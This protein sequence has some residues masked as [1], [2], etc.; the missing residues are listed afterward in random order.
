[1]KKLLFTLLLII[2]SLIN[3]SSS[4]ACDG[5]LLE[6]LKKERDIYLGD[7]HGTNEIPRL[8]QCL[9]EQLI[10]LDRKEPLVVALE[11]VTL[12]LTSNSEVWFGTDGRNSAAM[13]D[14]IQYLKE[15]KNLGNI[16][17]FMLLDAVDFSLIGEPFDQNI[18]EKQ[19]GIGLRSIVENNQVIALSGSFH[20]KK[21]APS[22]A[23]NIVPAGSYVSD[24]MLHVAIETIEDGESW[25]CISTGCSVKKSSSIG[26]A[27]TQAGEM[28]NG[29]LVDHDY[30]YFLPK[31]TASFPKFI[32]SK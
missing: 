16:N 3:I 22:F 15:Q 4:Y 13:W 26:I 21:K 14:L 32:K 23:P 19:I 11:E 8:L 6:L 28:V 17:L 10:K 5:P 20:T 27:D 12:G 9:V 25:G 31:F 24:L 29:N 30:I 18:Y 7:T 1:M 2:T